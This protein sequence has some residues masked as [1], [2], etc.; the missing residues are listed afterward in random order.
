MRVTRKS[1]LRLKAEGLLFLVLF[2]GAAGITAHLST[3]YH[4]QLDW[5]AGGRNTSRRPVRPCSPASRG[6]SP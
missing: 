2:L 5:T 4:T 1:R 6:R 3:R